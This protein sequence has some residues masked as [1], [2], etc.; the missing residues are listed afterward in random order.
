MPTEPQIH[1]FVNCIV[2]YIID[3][4]GVWACA[5]RPISRTLW[6]DFDN[7][8]PDSVDL[9]VFW[10]VSVSQPTVFVG[11]VSVERVVVPTLVLDWACHSGRLCVHFRAGKK[12]SR[13]ARSIAT[14]ALWGTAATRTAASFSGRCS[15]WGDGHFPSLGHR[16]RQ[17]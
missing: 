7:S 2:D 12:R 11:L 3:R 6:P 5:N 16:S 8:D 15:T 1:A 17:S 9:G 13:T 10:P 14:G 4:N